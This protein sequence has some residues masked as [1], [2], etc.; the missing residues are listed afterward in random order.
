MTEITKIIVDS[1]NSF[2][3][4]NNLRICGLCRTLRTVMSCLI[5]VPYSYIISRSTCE[6]NEKS[7]FEHLYISVMKL[8]MIIMLSFEKLVTIITFFPTTLWQ[9]KALLVYCT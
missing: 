4:S 6:V 8:S 5:V 2:T 7:S 3:A 1:G 9:G